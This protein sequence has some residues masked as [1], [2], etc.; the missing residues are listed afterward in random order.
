MKNLQKY[1]NPDTGISHFCNNEYLIKWTGTK[2]IVLHRPTQK[3]KYDVLV[4]ATGEIE[5]YGFREFT[6]EQFKTDIENEV[7]KQA[8]LDMAVEIVNYFEK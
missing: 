3:V 2:I 4:H 6:G 7:V 1:T 5:V 8:C